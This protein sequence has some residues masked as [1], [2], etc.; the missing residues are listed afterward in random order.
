MGFLVEVS[1]EQIRR[2]KEKARELRKSRWWKNQIAG[3][4]CHYCGA[5]VAPQELT[6]DHVVP[7]IRG[8]LSVKNNCVPACR[9][10]NSRKKYL[11]PL[12]WAQY[13]EGLRKASEEG[14]EP[15][16]SP[17]PED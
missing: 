10:C 9:D 17:V 6:L 5:R 11:L 15:P 4:V 3:G 16:D 12:E 8:G 2:E 13:L 1:D 7:I 14:R